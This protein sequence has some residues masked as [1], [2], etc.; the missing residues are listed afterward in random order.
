MAISLDVSLLVTLFWSKSLDHTWS[1][2]N[3]QHPISKS[4]QIVVQSWHCCCAFKFVDAKQLAESSHCRMNIR[5]DGS[6]LSSAASIATF[7]LYAPSY[8]CGPAPHKPYSAKN[9]GWY[10]KVQQPSWWIRH[11]ELVRYVKIIDLSRYSSN[12]NSFLLE[13]QGIYLRSSFRRSQCRLDA[14]AGLLPDVDWD[15]WCPDA[16]YRRTWCRRWHPNW[17]QLQLDQKNGWALDVH[18]A[19]LSSGLDLCNAWGL[20]LFR[21]CSSAFCPLWPLGACKNITSQKIPDAAL[22]FSTKSALPPSTWGE[23]QS[24]PWRRGLLWICQ[25]DPK[26]PVSGEQNQRITKKLNRTN[27]FVY[28]LFLYNMYSM[29]ILALFPQHVSS[30]CPHVFLPD[31]PR[32]TVPGLQVLHGR[33][34]NSRSFRCW[35]RSAP[36]GP[37]LQRRWINQPTKQINKQTNIHTY[38]NNNNKKNKKNTCVGLVN[39]SS[40]KA[41][42]YIVHCGSPLSSGWFLLTATPSKHLSKKKQLAFRPHPGLPRTPGTSWDVP[43]PTSHFES[44]LGNPIS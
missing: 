12:K 39:C 9:L 11:D 28:I 13:D 20:D 18:Q 33:L 26:W 38:N 30:F 40:I 5:S 10:S 35:F 2:W 16:P 36:V 8:R 23:V 32:C 6:S 34:R 7:L 29:I 24:Y 1:H 21:V 4:G 17:H 22:T 37:G 19:S 44:F 27:V 3:Q 25:Y 31:L 14:V 43:R 15:L 42:E 41:L